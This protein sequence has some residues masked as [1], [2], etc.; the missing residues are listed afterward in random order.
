MSEATPVSAVEI[1]R[2]LS[3]RQSSVREIVSELLA[4][5]G[6]DRLHAWVALDPDLLYLRAEQL[7]S[8]DGHRRTELPLFGIPVAIK[9][10]IDTS[11]LPTAYG[12]PI[13]AGQQPASDAL[14][15]ARL[16]ALGALV[17]GKTA[18][19]EFAWM[20]APETVNPIDN[21]RT[22]GGSSSGSA[23]TVADG[24]V[25]LALGTQTA[26]SVNRPASYC[27]V[28]GYTPSFG[29]Y[30]RDGVK[31][32]STAL[33]TIGTFAR[34]IDDLRLLDGAIRTGSAEQQPTE[35]PAKPLRIGFAPSPFWKRIEPAAATAIE[36]AIEHFRA[37][38]NL[39]PDPIELPHYERLAE[40]QRLIQWYESSR[41]L[42]GELREHRAALSEPL[43]EALTE[44]EAINRQDYDGARAAADT[45][46]RQLIEKLRQYSAILVPSTVD[47]PPTGITFTGDPLL[48][49][50]WTLIHAPAISLPIA[51]T[52]D[53]LPAGLQLVSAPGTDMLLHAAA[54]QLMTS[55]SA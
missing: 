37:A 13:Y 43:R 10:N 29:R 19:A 33:D 16:R 1:Q 52:V 35:R 14:V 47:V 8:L 12:S 50:V 9:D 25:P 45:L 46:G 44:G 40:A 2:R 28:I 42:R 20:T 27:G 6:D 30:P 24:Q 48:S 31:L 32:M 22:P 7:D 41:S 49:R 53:G 51:W 38:G 39:L 17:A 18:C 21:T 26:G 4:T 5:V 11:D 34:S 15:V 3:Q 54:A 36:S 55:A 23:A